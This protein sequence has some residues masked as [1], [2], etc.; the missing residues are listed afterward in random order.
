[1]STDLAV[2]QETTNC[3]DKVKKCSKC[4]KIKFFVDFRTDNKRKDKKHP[5]CKQ[6]CAEYNK[7]YESRPEVKKR[8]LELGRKYYANNRRKK[9][10]RRYLQKY[11]ITIEQKEQFLKNQDNKCAICQTTDPGSRNWH[12]DHDHKK[13]VIRGILCE[14]CNHGLGVFKDNK[15]FLYNAYVYLQ[16][17]GNGII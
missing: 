11:G 15:D 6:C 13:N 17:R 9:A 7:E 14:N 2:R 8:S 12:L 10:N 3:E 1:M 16:L 4:K 5:Q